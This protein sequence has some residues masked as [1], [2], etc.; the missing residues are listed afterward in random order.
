MELSERYSLQKQ[1]THNQKT[2]M[3]NFIAVIRVSEGRVF[4]VM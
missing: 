1:S 3:R 4:V 2:E